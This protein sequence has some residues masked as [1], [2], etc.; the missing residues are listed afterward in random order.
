M[1]PPAQWITFRASQRQ[2]DELSDAAKTLR[3][4]RSRLIRTLIRD[5]LIQLQDQGLAPRG[6]A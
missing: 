3:V 4:P 6:M 5:G 2:V 1:N